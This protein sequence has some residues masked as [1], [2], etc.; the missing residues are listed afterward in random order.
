MTADT[1]DV[2]VLIGWTENI[3]IDFPNPHAIGYGTGKY[4]HADYYTSEINEDFMQ[5][6][7]GWAGGNDYEREVIF[8]TGTSTKQQHEY[9]V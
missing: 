2:K 5:I 9:H 3:R 4:L 1:M 8:R 7:A 6:N